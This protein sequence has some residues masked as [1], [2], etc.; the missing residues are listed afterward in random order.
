MVETVQRQPLPE[1]ALLTLVVEVAEGLLQAPLLHLELA[2][3]E[4]AVMAVTQ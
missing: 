2:E 3:P 4:A 1:L